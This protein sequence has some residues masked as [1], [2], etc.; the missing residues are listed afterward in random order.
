MPAQ[1]AYGMDQDAGATEEGSGLSG[2]A[3]GS[4]A[5]CFHRPSLR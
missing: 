4:S 1:R 3:G 2:G 5:A